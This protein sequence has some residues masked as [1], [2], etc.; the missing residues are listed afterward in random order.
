MHEIDLTS[1]SVSTESLQ[2]IVADTL[3]LAAQRGA[4]QAEAGLTVSEG[5][6]VTARM[7]SVE[8]VE[9]QKDN[10]L[11]ISVPTPTGWIEATILCWFNRARSSG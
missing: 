1:L 4:T 2:N 10:G 9:F 11:G 7:R 5:L 8:T 3:Q 6:S